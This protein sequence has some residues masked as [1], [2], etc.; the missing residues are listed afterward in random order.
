MFSVIFPWH[1][2]VQ[3][4]GKT[5]GKTANASAIRIANLTTETEEH[6][7]CHFYCWCLLPHWNRWYCAKKGGE[8]FPAAAQH[9]PRIRLGNA[10]SINSLFFPLTFHYLCGFRSWLVSES[11]LITP[12]WLGQQQ[13]HFCVLPITTSFRRRFLCRLRATPVN[14][15]PFNQVSL[16]LLFSFTH[17]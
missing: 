6:I 2:S 15:T 8:A 7:I 4:A 1:N 14:F 12:W 17:C 5:S 11:G 16:I 9:I 3:Q 10:D 13:S